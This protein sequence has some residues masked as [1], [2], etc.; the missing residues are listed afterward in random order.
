MKRHTRSLYS[1]LPV[2]NIRLLR[3]NAD[4]SASDSGSLQ[5]A[6]FNEAPPYYALSHCWGA[7]SRDVE[8]RIDCQSFL[9]CLDLAAGIRR[10]REL[11]VEGSGMDPPVKYVWI[12]NICINQDDI[13]ERLAQV[14]IMDKIYSQ[15]IRTLIWLG[16]DLSGS[17]RAWQLVDRI[18]SVFRAQHPTATT[19]VDIP[20]KMYSDASHASSG[21]PDWNDNQW[22]QLRQLM[23]LNWFSRIWVVQ[24]VVL[25]PRDPIILHGNVTYQW[26]RL[27]WVAAWMRRNGYIRL[28][29]IAEGFRNVDTIR[30]LQ[31]AGS[32]WPLAALM[33][34]TQIKFHATDQRDKIYGLLGLAAESQGRSKLP[35]PLRPDYGSDVTEVY[36]RIAQFLLEQNHSLAILTRACGASNDIS[37]KQRQHNLNLP[38]WVP[39]WSDFRVFN[40]GLRTSF[41]W[42][43]YSDTT[44]P[45][46]LGF[47]RQYS[48]SA[49]LELK[50]H[51]A[52]D[53]ST[54]QVSGM[55][56][57]EVVR[58]VL[59]SP[60]NLSKN[61]FGQDTTSQILR[62]FEAAV[63]LL[64]G[65]ELESWASHFI[66]TTSAE[67]HRL[68]GRTWDQSFR[69]GCSFLHDLLLH[70]EAQSSMF[71]SHCGDKKALDLL[72][73]L[74]D[75]G[76][77]EEYSALVGNFCFDRSFVTT[78]KGRMGIGPSDTR[79]GDTV[80]VIPGGGV[81]YIMR[82]NGSGW[83]L[84]G[85]SY[86]AGLM[87]GEA[88]QAHQQGLIQDEILDLR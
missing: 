30:N 68:G 15:S 47:P 6:A 88:I 11:A 17:T 41:S 69:D 25:S 39:D 70:N 22:L 20:L 86:I 13:S 51:K 37:R 80:S 3:I 48:A 10:L 34:I 82:Q 1:T 21:L 44:K 4:T 18:Y 83:A 45:A 26:H 19:L 67:Q 27:G 64:K 42:I 61:E 31:R 58:V 5:L 84:V 74:S 16:T 29:E 79:V 33:S 59:F 14:K 24:E 85:E 35:D 38:S 63:C 28:A 87:N 53:S 12:D 52:V 8:I 65:K 77:S 57:D 55:R 72:H 40:R 36:R 73:N 71:L 46:H 49:E 76:V 60:D 54:L 50:L 62:V 75:G 7:Q 32:R 78:S 81:P 56:L 2:N 9:V 23:E 66:K 43:D